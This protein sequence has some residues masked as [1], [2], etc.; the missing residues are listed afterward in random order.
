MPEHDDTGSGSGKHDT[1]SISSIHTALELGFG[2]INGRLSTVDNR[3][4]AMDNQLTLISQ[5][6][7]SVGTRIE[8]VE[9][10]CHEHRQ[11]SLARD[12][13]IS[14]LQQAVGKM[15]LL[16]AHQT[17]QEKELDALR[18]QIEKEINT[19]HSHVLTRDEKTDRYVEDITSQIRIHQKDDLTSAVQI[20]ATWTTLQRVGAALLGAVGLGSASVGVYTWL[21]PAMS[22]T[23][24]A[25]GLIAVAVCG[26]AFG[27][28]LVLLKGLGGKRVSNSVTRGDS[29][30]PAPPSIGPTVHL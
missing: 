10:Q 13:R 27:S 1:G 28:G 12:R 2:M 30:S 11:G 9:R 17:V 24:D 16:E 26:V 19:L 15:P 29:T 20:Q 8:S 23:G 14:E 25:I 18:D 7:S 21:R 22:T 3:L 6:T 4:L 5:A